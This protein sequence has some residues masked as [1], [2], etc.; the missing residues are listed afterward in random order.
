[1]NE[2]IN[3]E[4][5]QDLMS[6]FLFSRSRD[7]NFERGASETEKEFSFFFEQFSLRASMLLIYRS[8]G[9]SNRKTKPIE[10]ICRARRNF[11]ASQTSVE[12]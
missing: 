6:V 8:P 2:R 4:A 7:M 5:K 11:D 9:A 3:S 1:M 10:S 12:L